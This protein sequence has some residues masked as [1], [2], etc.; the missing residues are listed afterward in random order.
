MQIILDGIY[1]GLTLAILLGPIFI[2]LL[3]TS[4]EYGWRAGMIAAL[5][6]WISDVLIVAMTLAFVRR[7]RFLVE[8]P[9]F[10]YWMGL[11]GGAVLITV[12]V[13][14]TLKKSNLELDK[15]VTYKKGGWLKHIMA[16]LL[17]N[18]INPF[19]FLFWLT[20]I[21]SYVATKRLEAWE[22]YLFAGTIIVMIIL[23]D[24]IKVL[25]ARYIRPKVTTN[26]LNIINKIAGSALIIFGF[27]LLMRSVYYG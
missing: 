22:C 9:D 25:A 27:V 14:T 3:Q 8:N 7:I 23:T 20:T 12:G 21:T 13:L 5:G 6:I 16:G 18:T 24:T 1:L 19:T 4:I 2:I 11:V 17:V 26:T 15:E 10:I